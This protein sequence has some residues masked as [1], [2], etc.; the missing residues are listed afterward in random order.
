MDG[1]SADP[2]RA[3]IRVG[4][5]GPDSPTRDFPHHQ[6]AR[7]ALKNGRPKEISAARRAPMLCVS[8]LECERVCVCLHRAAAEI[9]DEMVRNS[10]LCVGVYGCTEQMLQQTTDVRSYKPEQA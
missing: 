9:H 5:I 2:A 6:P 10:S 8:T 1:G 4:L 7:L 3:G